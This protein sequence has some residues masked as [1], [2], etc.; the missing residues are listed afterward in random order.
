MRG[1]VKRR[2]PNDVGVRA[3][4]DA[5]VTRATERDRN[6][7]SVPEQIADGTTTQIPGVQFASVESDFLDSLPT[8]HDD[9]PFVLAKAYND[10]YPDHARLLRDSAI[11]PMVA[12]ERGY[13]ST[14][15]ASRLKKT[16]FSRSQ[17]RTPGLLIPQWSLDGD[18]VSYQFRP[19]DPRE[20]NGKPIK[21]ESPKG[22]H[23]RLDVHPRIRPY[24]GDPNIALFITEGARKADAAISQGLVCIGLAGVWGWRGTNDVG[25]K[26]AL[27]DFE[28]V[29]L[30]DR[31][32]YLVFDSDVM[33]KASV[34][35]AL[36]RLRGFLMSRDAIVNVIYLPEQM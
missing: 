29:A 16:G 23:N 30:N 33:T 26:V 27:A 28:T 36:E 2:D 10:V 14:Y 20:V 18:V 11:D 22:S 25:G 12:R 5:R 17:Q 35:G 19:D 4:R 9:D 1:Q 21:Y 34:R 7:S 24:I 13:E 31:I 6:A 32:V 3:S 8:P 15:N